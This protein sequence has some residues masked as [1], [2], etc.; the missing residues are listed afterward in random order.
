MDSGYWNYGNYG[1]LDRYGTVPGRSTYLRKS[2]APHRSSLRGEREMFSKRPG[3][4]VPYVLQDFTNQWEVQSRA[5][6]DPWESGPFSK[7]KKVKEMCCEEFDERLAREDLEGWEVNETLER[8]Y[9]ERERRQRQEE[10]E[11]YLNINRA[12]GFPEQV[13]RQPRNK[14][15]LTKRPLPLLS[16]SF[17]ED[18][19]PLYSRDFSQLP[20]ANQYRQREVAA[21]CKDQWMKF[22]SLTGMPMVYQTSDCPAGSGKPNRKRERFLPI[23]LRAK[24]TC[25]DLQSLRA[26]KC[27][28]R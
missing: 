13:K 25:S 20:P 9:R 26:T 18:W 28:C 15:K 23:D 1:S 3:Q 8:Y 7:T 5:S 27:S 11:D 14:Q 22:L 19:E 6:P 4:Q 16:E 17:Y 12:W 2:F 21:H 10:K 24:V